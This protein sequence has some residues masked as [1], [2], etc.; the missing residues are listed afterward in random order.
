M[1]IHVKGVS[2]RDILKTATSQRC[3]LYSQYQAFFSTEKKHFF[4]KKFP[5]SMNLRFL[6]LVSLMTVRLNSD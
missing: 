3:L 1:C 5:G 2:V 6:V 4:E